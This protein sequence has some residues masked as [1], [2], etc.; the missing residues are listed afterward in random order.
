[1]GNIAT[2]TGLMSIIWQPRLVGCHIL[3]Y[4]CYIL[5]SLWQL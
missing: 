5:S 2:Y 4:P 1:M 3:M